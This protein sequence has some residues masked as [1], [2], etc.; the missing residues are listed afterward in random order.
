MAIKLLKKSQKVIRGFPT[1]CSIMSQ[2]KKD[3]AGFSCFGAGGMVVIIV[4]V[5]PLKSVFKMNETRLRS[6]GKDISRGR[7]AD[8]EQGA[9]KKGGEQWGERG[10]ALSVPQR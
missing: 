1:S 5:I 6:Q 7:V 2:C 9:D 3:K 4:S 10:T 8:N